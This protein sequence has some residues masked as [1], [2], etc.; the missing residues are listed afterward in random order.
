M[1]PSPAW[2]GVIAFL[3]SLTDMAFLRKPALSNPWK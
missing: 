2:V 3:E 1:D